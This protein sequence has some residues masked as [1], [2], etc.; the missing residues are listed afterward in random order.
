MGEGRR[1]QGSVTHVWRVTTDISPPPAST[2][3]Y[4]DQATSPITQCTGDPFSYGSSGSW[5]T[6]AI[7]NT[8][9][10]VGAAKNLAATQTLFYEPPGRS[11]T[12]AQTH[13]TQTLN[14]MSVS[15]TPWRQT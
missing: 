5:I 15:V 13:A 14:P 10:H 3:Y 2:N 8:D 11:T 1:S 6:G 12:N 7:P 9:P 4:Y